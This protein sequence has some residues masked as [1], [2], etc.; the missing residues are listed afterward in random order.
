[1]IT[2]IIPT[3]NEEK[4]IGEIIRYV[5]TKPIVTEIIVIDDG[6]TDNTFN[7]A[8]KEGA[9]VYLS[10]LLGKGAS[11]HDGLVRSKNEKVLFLDG[12]IFNFSNELID[13][14][15]QPLLSE[16]ADFVKGKFHRASGRVTELTAKP[17]LK[18]FF[19]E[20]LA[21]EQPLGGIIAANRDFLNNI[22][23]ENDYGVDIGLLIDVSQLGARITEIE[24]GY[25]DHDHQPLEAL[26]KMS[27]QVV[28]TIL[29]KASKYRRLHPFSIGD[30]SERER[31][32][33][34]QYGSILQELEENQ[35][36]VLFDMDGT[37]IEGS[38]IEAITHYTGLRHELNGLLGN[39][40]LDSRYRT[41]MIAQVLRG[42]PKQTFEKI[43]RTIPLKP[44]AQE[45]IIELRKSG[46]RVGIITD[47][48]FIASEIIRRRIFA[49]FSIAHLL[50]F[51]KGKA[52]GEITLSP[53]MQFENGCKEHQICKANFIHHLR[54]ANTSPN[55][56][57][58]LSVG[59][60][61]N[62]ICL[63]K[64]SEQSFAI[65]P[66]SPD[67]TANAKTK[68]ANLKELLKYV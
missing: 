24:V 52:T 22:K 47:S 60:G 15:I 16:E 13:S 37:L 9:K 14:M 54:A 65:Y 68:I 51:N 56:H 7:I 29:T 66:Q 6:S 25:L 38:F 33:K 48:Y 61:E 64:H 62:D 30:S 53:F 45:T 42:I 1:M 58:V 50:D 49:D 17:L 10:S 39:H 27:L 57:Q 35:P 31:F 26:S 63:F 32:E 5:K 8:K 12:D 40:Q 23:F 55:D 28:R 2:V 67:V 59:N 43:A 44:H 11:M 20:L 34:F 21:F 3:L 36:V 46:Y 19:P 4:R 41:K 18:I